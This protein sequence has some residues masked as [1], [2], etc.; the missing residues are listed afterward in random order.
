MAKE[1][2]AFRP[3]VLGIVAELEKVVK[4]QNIT[5]GNEERMSTG[6]LVVDLMLGGGI[7]AGM[8]TFSGAEQSAKTTLAINVLAASVNQDVDLRVLWDAEGSSGSSMDYIENIFET[9]KVKVDIETLFGTRVKGKYTKTPLIYYR[10]EGEMD[11]FFNWLSGLLRRLP[12]KRFDDD[13]WWYVYE[14]NQENK[15]KFKG[16]YNRDLSSANNALYIPAPNGSLQAIILPDSYPSLMPPA[17]DSDDPNQSI[18]MQAREFS[19]NLPRV[20]GRLRAKRVALMG[21]NQLRIN[22]MARFTDPNYEPGGNALGYYSDVRIRSTARALS[23]VPYNP[24]GKKLEEEPSVSGDGTDKYRYIHLKTIKNK[25]SV[26]GREAWARIW[27]GD[28]DD[29][30]RGFCPVWDTFYTLVM[31]G[32]VTGKR[33]SMTLSL[34]GL[35]EAKRAID[36]EKFKMLV[37]GDKEQIAWVCKKMGYA[38]AFNLRKGLFNMLRKGKLEELYVA[39]H[40]AKLNKAKEKVKDDDD[41]EED[42]D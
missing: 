13:R 36:W 8:Y 41:D 7:T 25:L 3:D 15:A 42:D 21:I 1:K 38:K 37:L 33:S 2:D 27:V 23:S 12:D 29:R 30:A 40:R 28:E 5:I 39:E 19:K 24:K 32:Q 9:N 4:I 14:N 22:P 11:T 34:D 20:K 10:D 6:L 17:M 26:P 16:Q 31:T 35:G 18:A